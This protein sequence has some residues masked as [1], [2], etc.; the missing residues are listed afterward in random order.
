MRL[1]LSPMSSGKT[2]SSFNSQLIPPVKHSSILRIR[3][4]PKK[5]EIQNNND[6][7]EI[8]KLIINDDNDHIS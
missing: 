2:Y 5:L 7:F 8:V 3:N 6:N 1:H 4:S